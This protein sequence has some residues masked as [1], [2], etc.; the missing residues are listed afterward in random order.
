MEWNNTYHTRHKDLH[1]IRCSGYLVERAQHQEERG[2]VQVHPCSDLH[3]EF[4]KTK[5]WKCKS[6]LCCQKYTVPEKDIHEAKPNAR[7]QWRSSS[8]QMLFLCF[9]ECYFYTG[10]KINNSSPSQIGPPP[11]SSI[12]I[13]FPDF[14]AAANM[15]QRLPCWQGAGFNLDRFTCTAP[16]HPHYL[17][18]VIYSVFTIFLTVSCLKNDLKWLRFTLLRCWYY[19]YK[20]LNVLELE[21]LCF[22]LV[23]Y[24]A[25]ASVPFD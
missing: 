11:Q 24:T 25:P 17:K 9:T 3:G 23:L 15:S 18:W 10:E 13:M 5:E 21:P 12:R 6:I 2:T 1:I 8:V 7:M 19:I 4:R 20:R 14:A 16:S 22:Q